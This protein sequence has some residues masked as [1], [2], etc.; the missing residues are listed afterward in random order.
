MGNGSPEDFLKD[1]ENF[2]NITYGKVNRVI[3][4]ITADLFKAIIE[5]T[6]VDSGRARS[7]WVFSVGTPKLVY[8]NEDRDE[9][10][11]AA[12]GFDRTGVTTM[13]K[14]DNGLKRA[15]A[16]ITGKQKKLEGI[17]Y[18]LTNC[19][20]YITKLEYGGYTESYI[21]KFKAEMSEKYPKRKGNGGSNLSGT[22]SKQAPQGMVRKNI[23]RFA[24]MSI[25]KY[26]LEE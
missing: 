7:S 13:D 12:K 25:D 10:G 6:P 19:T 5:D 22:F 21:E 17:D 8:P 11:N 9:Y 2:K 20:S 24:N 3:K 1:L 18:Y 16:A 14:V 15:K 23:Q 26:K 4:Y